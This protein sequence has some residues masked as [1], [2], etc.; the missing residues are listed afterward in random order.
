MSLGDGAPGDP[1][2]ADV[3][4]P[5]AG[6][7]AELDAAA[8]LES[9]AVRDNDGPGDALDAAEPASLEA[10]RPRTN[11]HA[12]AQ[13]EVAAAHPAGAAAQADGDLVH[14]NRDLAHG[15]AGLPAAMDGFERSATAPQLRRFIKS[16]A[17][18]PMHELR[19]RFV[20]N[21]D[22]D[23]VTPI[24]VG[25]DRIYVGLPTHEGGLLGELFRAGDIGYELSMDPIAPIVVGVYPMRPVPRG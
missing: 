8:V 15:N 11:G 5:S 4:Q 24:D 20:I 3:G 17:Y 12:A 16:R 7:A 14:G 18:V 1:P 6:F 2:A 22:D 19:R 23:D 21:G 13:T 10:S 25:Q 9:M